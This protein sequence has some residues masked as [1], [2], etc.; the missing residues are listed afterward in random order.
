MEEFSRVYRDA[1]DAYQISHTVGM[2]RRTHTFQRI[3]SRLFWASCWALL[4][5]VHER[6]QGTY[7]RPRSGLVH[8]FHGAE[9]N[10]IQAAIEERHEGSDER[11][12]AE[13]SR[14][15]IR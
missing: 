7:I 14:Y 10:D 1:R 4:C 2:A 3:E 12:Q 11:E 13:R 8:P 5:I 6:Q 9:P 15:D